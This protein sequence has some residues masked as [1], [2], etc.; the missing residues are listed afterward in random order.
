MT[1]LTPPADHNSALSPEIFL[2]FAREARIAKRALDEAS[3][4]Y[5]HVMK[6]AKRAGIDL[7]EFKRALAEAL[8]DPDQKKASEEA[9]A[10]YMAWLG[11]PVGFQ[12]TLEIVEPS[13]RAKDALQN[14][15]WSQEGYDAALAGRGPDNSPYTAGSLADSFWRTGNSDGHAFKNKLPE[16]EAKPRKPRKGKVTAETIN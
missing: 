2:D 13:Q 11:K 16:L 4:G 6:R 3:S 5:Q 15:I 1:A 7:K 9:Y 8:I 14:E 12:A 10:K